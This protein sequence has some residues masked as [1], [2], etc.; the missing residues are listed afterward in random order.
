MKSILLPLSMTLAT[1]LTASTALGAALSADDHA[2][3]L[4]VECSLAQVSVDLRGT[5]PRPDGS[6]V[7][8]ETAFDVTVGCLAGTTTKQMQA[9]SD[10]VYDVCL[11]A[12]GEW[13]SCRQIGDEIA[14]FAGE[15][16]AVLSPEIPKGITLRLA[17][18]TSYA[19]QPVLQLN[20]EHTLYDGQVEPWTWIFRRNGQFLGSPDGWEDTP[21]AQ[22]STCTAESAIG[23]TGQLK[24]RA[25]TMDATLKVWRDLSCADGPVSYDASFTYASPVDG[26]VR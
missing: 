17:P 8:F 1:T 12:E 26:Y 10:R 22:R 3:T 13:E 9:V 11:A 18:R 21:E 24:R 16:D 15:Y 7:S 2:T 5:A 6:P 14:G 23:L 25:G 20:A 4:D 19:P